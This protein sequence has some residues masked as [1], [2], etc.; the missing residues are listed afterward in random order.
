M[1]LGLV[2][3]TCLVAMSNAEDGEWPLSLD[4]YARYGRQMIM[5]EWGLGSESSAQE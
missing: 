3:F 5:P 1:R 4:E 2:L